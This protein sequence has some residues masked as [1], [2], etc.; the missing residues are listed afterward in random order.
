MVTRMRLDV[1][2]M[3]TLSLSFNTS[4]MAFRDWA[5]YRSEDFATASQML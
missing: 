5:A 1:S 3:S 2:F 4:L